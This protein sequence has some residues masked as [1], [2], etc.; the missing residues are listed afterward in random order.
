MATYRRV[1]REVATRHLRPRDEER[2]RKLLREVVRAPAAD[3]VLSARLCTALQATYEGLHQTGRRGFLSVLAQQFGTDDD[4]VRQCSRTLLDAIDTDASP[5]AHTSARV[6]QAQASLRTALTPLHERVMR[7]VVQ[8]PGGLPFL[9]Q[10]RSDLLKAIKER[11]N[12]APDAADDADR[13]AAAEIERP[14]MRALDASLLRLLSSRFDAVQLSLLS[15]QWDASPAALLDRLMKYE[16]VHPMAGWHDLRGRLGD[17]RRLFAFTHPS[18][19]NEPLVFVQA[20]SRRDRAEIGMD[21]TQLGRFLARS[22]RDLGCR[23]RF[24]LRCPRSLPSAS[25][26]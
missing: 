15:V 14:F 16:R 4:S 12:P 2:I 26:T 22:L 25:P 24:S 13:D 7:S 3:D 23:W 11:P 17:H 19:E 10:M 5:P 21:S 18:M 6:L 20:R 9:I 8:Q 1:L